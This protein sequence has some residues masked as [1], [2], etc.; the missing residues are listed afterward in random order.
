MLNYVVSCNLCADEYQTHEKAPAICINMV[1][2]ASIGGSHSW[3]IGGLR[4]N[5]VQ[6]VQPY[7][8]FPRIL[9]VIL[10]PNSK[11]SLGLHCKYMMLLA[12]D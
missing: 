5:I 10:Y 9:K 1:F 8:S 2:S 12:V 6:L 3:A 7:I 11:F 4:K